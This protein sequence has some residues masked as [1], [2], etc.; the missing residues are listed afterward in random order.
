M[1]ESFLDFM[2]SKDS[3]PIPFYRRMML[4][5]LGKIAPTSR[6]IFIF[7]LHYSGELC[8]FRYD[9]ASQRVITEWISEM[10]PS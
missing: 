4:T 5:E 6:S 1:S 10:R 8:N 3:T 7:W 2:S 9:S